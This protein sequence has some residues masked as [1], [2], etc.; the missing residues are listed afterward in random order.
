M[1]ERRLGIKVEVNPPKIVTKELEGDIGETR[2]GYRS[3]W[4]SSAGTGWG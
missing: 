2:F 4:W 3:W 1:G